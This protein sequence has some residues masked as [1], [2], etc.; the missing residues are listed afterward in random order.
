[1]A[2]PSH[3]NFFQCLGKFACLPDLFFGFFL[4]FVGVFSSVFSESETYRYTTTDDSQCSGN[5]PGSG[6]GVMRLLMG[7]LLVACAHTSYSSKIGLADSALD[8]GK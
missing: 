5:V 8:W 7:A 6:R 3:S 2:G 4:F 1:M